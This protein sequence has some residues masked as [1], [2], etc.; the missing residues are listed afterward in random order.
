[1][2]SNPRLGLLIAMTTASQVMPRRR[3]IPAVETTHPT[4]CRQ[5]RS[6]EKRARILM[7]RTNLK[8]TAMNWW[9]N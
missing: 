9:Q 7:K 3:P 2:A 8:V 6:R 1:M 4:N 5:R